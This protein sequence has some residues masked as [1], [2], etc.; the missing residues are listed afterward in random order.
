MFCTISACRTLSPLVPQ[1]TSMGCKSQ[2][3]LGDLHAGRHPVTY[4][5]GTEDE[6]I[7]HGIEKL[8]PGAYEKT[9]STR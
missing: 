3:Q 4:T 7:S 1:I 8:V 2:T 9:L 5:R 6:G